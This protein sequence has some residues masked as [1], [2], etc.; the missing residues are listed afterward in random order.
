MRLALYRCAGVQETRND[1]G[2]D[3]GDIAFE[4][5]RAVHHR[6]AGDADIVLDGDRFAFELAVR[7]AL[8]VSLYVPGVKRILLGARPI[9]GSAWIFDDGNLVG[10]LIDDIVSSKVAVHQ[11]N[12][13]ADAF[14]RHRHAEALDDV[15]HLFDCWALYTHELSLVPVVFTPHVGG[16]VAYADKFIDEAMPMQ[17]ARLGGM[18]DDAFLDDEDSLGQSGDEVEILLAK[19]H[20]HPALGPKVE[21]RL[22]NLID[23]RRLNAFGRFVQQNQPWIAR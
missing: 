7:R 4:G 3:V 14:L 18:H 12:E 10:H 22:R 11:R 16:L 8:N 6:H 21:K 17:F 20:L 9:P 19:D 13:L 15:G 1:G 2:V 5:R 23:D